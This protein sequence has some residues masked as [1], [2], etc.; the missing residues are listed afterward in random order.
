SA[1][2]TGLDELDRHANARQLKALRWRAAVAERLRSSV[3][4]HLAELDAEVVAQGG[5]RDAAI[6]VR[7]V[8]RSQLRVVVPETVQACALDRVVDVVG[9]RRFPTPVERPAFG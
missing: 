5:R 8:L 7:S 2:G 4:E 6:R 3:L 9:P 1:D